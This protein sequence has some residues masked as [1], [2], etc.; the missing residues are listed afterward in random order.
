MA[1]C[2]LYLLLY[3]VGWQHV[4]VAAAS[5]LQSTIMAHHRH[6]VFMIALLY[7]FW[8]QYVAMRNIILIICVLAAVRSV[9]RASWAELLE[10]DDETALLTALCPTM[11]SGIPTGFRKAR[12]AWSYRAGESQKKK[13]E[14]SAGMWELKMYGRQVQLQCSL[15]VVL[16]PQAAGP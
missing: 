16:Y 6:A 12:S 7:L 1:C 14:Q 15:L 9:R 5:L 10:E 3:A 13:D 8:N 11:F 4:H 2:L